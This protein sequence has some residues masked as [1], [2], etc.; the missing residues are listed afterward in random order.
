MTLGR[1]T[2]KLNKMTLPLVMAP[3]GRRA[4]EA[5]QPMQRAYEE[6]LKLANES[7]YDIGVIASANDDQM[8]WSVAKRRHD[9]VGA[10]RTLNFVQ[11]ALENGYRFD[12][13]K[14]PAKLKAFAT[15]LTALEE[16]LP[17][18]TELLAAPPMIHQDS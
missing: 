15:A 14:G 1:S 8:R 17:L 2:P 18:L 11:T 3:V 10:V 4:S 6:F 9:L 5:P 13:E 12:D 7:G 16:N